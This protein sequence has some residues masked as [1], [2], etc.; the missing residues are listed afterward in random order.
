M[1]LFPLTVVKGKRKKGKPQ[2]RVDE[3]RKWM[4]VALRHATKEPGAVAAMQGRVVDLKRPCVA[5]IRRISVL[6]GVDKKKASG[7][8]AGR[9]V[10]GGADRDRTDGLQSAILALSQLSYSPKQ[11]AT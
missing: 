5:L 8:Y 9:L 6:Q 7:N 2:L 4:K 10:K 1:P 3:A 11:R